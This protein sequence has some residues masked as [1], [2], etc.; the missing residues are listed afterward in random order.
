MSPP[1]EIDLHRMK[2]ETALGQLE[3]ELTYCRA[4]GV[5]SLRVIVGR[6]WHS[7]GQRP[8][9]A[10]AVRTWLLGPKGR[11]LGVKDCQAENR[12]GALLVR[13]QG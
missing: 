4:G 3:Q 9:L 8:V 6:G 7:P 11:A 10:P 13:L 1:R 12:G 2:V 5:R